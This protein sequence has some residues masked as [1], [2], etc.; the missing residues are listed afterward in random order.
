MVAMK[1]LTNVFTAIRNTGF[2]GMLFL[3]TFYSFQW[4]NVNAAFVYNPTPWTTP[5]AAQ[6]IFHSVLLTLNYI[7]LFFGLCVAGEV[8]SLITG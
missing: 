2:F 7:Y 8:G 5:F 1:R 3:L 6:A 4:I